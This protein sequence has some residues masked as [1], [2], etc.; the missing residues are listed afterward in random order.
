MKLRLIM[1]KGE[2]AFSYDIEGKV[3]SIG[4][5]NANDIQIHDKR[6][7]RHH[8]VVWTEGGRYWLKDLGSGNGTYVNGYRVP[9][10]ATVGVKEG[11]AISIGWS[12]FCLGEGSSGDLF[13]FLDLLDSGKRRGRD[14]TTVL[15][16]ENS[17]MAA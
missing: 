8:L 7:S 2:D 1:N 15:V 10:G 6:V 4:R 14:T 3:I 9:S 5:S 17:V 13:S 12:V 16:E 11:F